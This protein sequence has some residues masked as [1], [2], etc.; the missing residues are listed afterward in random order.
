MK[1]HLIEKGWY[2]IGSGVTNINEPGLINCAK[3]LTQ[4][5]TTN[6]YFQYPDSN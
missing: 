5:L 6:V 2:T 3:K 1:H 4:K